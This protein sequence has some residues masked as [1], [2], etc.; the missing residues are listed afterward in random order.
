MRA[1]PEVLEDNR[2]RLAVEIDEQ[3]VEEALA[4]TAKTI[5]RQVRIPGFRPGHA[6]R[7]VVEAR[8]GGAK[9]LRTEAL[10]ELLPDYYARALSATELE[11]ISAPELNMTGGEEEGVVQFDAVVQVRP[12]VR[13][14]GY[15]DLRVTI[16]SPLASDA[17]LDQLLDRI[18]EADAELRGVA[19]PIV[20]G[21]YVTMDVRGRNESGE[22]QA[23][24]DDYV[25]PV[26]Q[27]TIVDTADDQLVGMRAGE[28]L[29]VEGHAPAGTF[30]S[31]TITLK[32]VRER[33]LPELT[34]EWVQENT[35]Y[36]TA[37]ELRDKSLE[38]IGTAKLAQAR[39][40][41]R[42]ATLGAL[43]A[44]VADD[45]VPASL[46][47]AE[48]RE[49]I[50]EFEQN[51]AASK[52]SFQTYLEATRL[53]TEQLIEM[54][55]ED[56]L[57]A[58]KV[59]LSLRAVASEEQLEPTSE[60]IDEELTRLAA[61]RKEKP[62]KL[63]DELVRAGRMGALRSSLT[64]QRAADW[65]LERVTFVDETGSEIGRSLLEEPEGGDEQLDQSAAA[66]EAASEEAP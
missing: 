23:S 26:G 49:R 42:D 9:A 56:S 27:G 58:I 46:L 15:G 47:D 7:Q 57:R 43:A 32:E 33:V 13:L 19:R 6:P 10:R 4:S 28:T 20:T 53:T 5:A 63:R 54:L 8:L 51:L 44:Q 50:E 31:C 59:D 38:R 65:V 22:E 14:T 24:V 25:Y 34:D 41:M 12:E 52:V 3:E 45:E 60:E 2:V 39:R 30:L 37:Q 1:T 62:Q 17:E 40:A 21:D 18:R 11:P 48:T 35:E 64:K 66:S 55:R 16:P 36:E 61:L 29:E